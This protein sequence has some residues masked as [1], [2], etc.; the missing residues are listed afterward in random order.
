[1]MWQ[2]VLIGYAWPV[3]GYNTIT[4]YFGYRQGSAVVSSYHSGL[5]I[6]APP[7]TYLVAICDGTIVNASWTGAGR[8]YNNIY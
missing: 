7:G 4:S 6:G 8:I 5:D 3:P 2:L 1:M